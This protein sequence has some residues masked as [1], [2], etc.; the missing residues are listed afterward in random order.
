[1]G[2]LGGDNWLVEWKYE[3]SA[4]SNNRINVYVVDR[5]EVI[6]KF[7]VASNFR[8]DEYS[9]F[10]IMKDSP[11]TR[12]GEGTC[13]VYDYN[14]DGFDEVFNYAF[15]GMGFFIYIIGCDSDN[16]ELVTHCDILF[17]IVD[18]RAGPAPIEFLEYKGMKGFK[19]YLDLYNQSPKHP[20]TKMAAQNRA[21]YFFAWDEKSQEFVEVCEYLEESETLESAGKIE[22]S[23]EAPETPSPTTAAAPEPVMTETAKPSPFIFVIIGIGAAVVI[24]IMVLVLRRKKP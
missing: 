9:A 24:I 7:I 5:D 21:W 4:N 17:D 1:M 15:S 3:I 16:N 2:I 22:L 13:A 23:N 10:D 18:P 14:G 11:G 8:M 12:I 19:V 20:P 6:K